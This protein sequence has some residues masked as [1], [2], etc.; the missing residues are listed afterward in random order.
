[1]LQGKNTP[2]RVQNTNNMVSFGRVSCLTA[3]AGDLMWVISNL[4][5]KNNA[6]ALALEPKVTARYWRRTQVFN[7]ALANHFGDL[8]APVELEVSA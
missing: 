7:A 8:C 4:A 2:T 6:K 5:D 3:E 1:M